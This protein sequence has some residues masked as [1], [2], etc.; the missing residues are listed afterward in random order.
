MFGMT[1]KTIRIASLTTYRWRQ[2]TKKRNTG[3]LISTS[4]SVCVSSFTSVFSS[5]DIWRTN[6]RRALIAHTTSAWAHLSV[7]IEVQSADKSRS[8]CVC[9]FGAARHETYAQYADSGHQ[10]Y[11]LRMNT[12]VHLLCDCVASRIMCSKTMKRLSARMPTVNMGWVGFILVFIEIMRRRRRRRRGHTPAH[13]VIFHD[14]RFTGTNEHGRTCVDVSAAADE[15][16][17]LNQEM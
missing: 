12:H 10:F 7:S 11:R 9:V 5:C 1:I 13:A 15:N 16:K 2:Q 17:K 6:D 14:D 4:M 8:V 3:Q